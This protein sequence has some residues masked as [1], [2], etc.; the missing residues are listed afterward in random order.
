MERMTYIC[1]SFLLLPWQVP[2]TYRVKTVQLLS[3][4]SEGQKSK[5]S[6]TELTIRVRLLLEVLGGEF[7]PQLLQHLD[8][9]SNMLRA[10]VLIHT[11]IYLHRQRAFSD[12]D[13]V[14]LFMITLSPPRK[15]RLVFPSQGPQLNHIGQFF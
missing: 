8:I 6:F 9:D 1:V 2:R 15:S 12:S 5:I 14:T 4:G 7:I 11:S 10:L 13:I 3:Y